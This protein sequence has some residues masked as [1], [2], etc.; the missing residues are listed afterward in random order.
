MEVKPELYAGS[1]QG[2]I[3]EV[4]ICILYTAARGEDGFLSTFYIAAKQKK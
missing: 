2:R 3:L 1:V 4:Y